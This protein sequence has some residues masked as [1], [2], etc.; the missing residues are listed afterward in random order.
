MLNIEEELPKAGGYGRYQHLLLWLVILPSQLPIGAQ[1]YFQFLSS[2]TPDHWCKVPRVQGD[3]TALYWSL[4]VAMARQYRSTSYLHSQCFINRTLNS[5]VMNERWKEGNR[6]IRDH[7]GNG[8]IT[9]C[10]HGWFYNRSLLEDSNTIVT[11]EHDENRKRNYD[12]SVAHFS[13]G[14][15]EKYLSFQNPKNITL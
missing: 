4:R 14:Y 1:L 11:E 15:I 2:W 6:R 3:N 7:V 5:N 13:L 9:G 10:Q 8:T 12:A